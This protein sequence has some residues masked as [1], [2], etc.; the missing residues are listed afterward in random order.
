MNPE[1][2]SQK[3]EVGGCSSDCG[4]APAAD[5]L[6]SDLGP[7][8]SGRTY[9]R[10]LDDLADTPEF[11]EFMHREFPAGASELLDSGDRRNFLKIMG[12]S[13]ALAGMSVGGLGGCRRWPVEHIVPYAARPENRVPGVPVQYATSMEIGGVAHGLLATSFDG[14]PIKIEGNPEHPINRGGT[15]AVTQASILD[16][17]DPDRSMSPVRVVDGER[18]NAT[19][20]EFA[21]WAQQRM[22]QTRARR[23]HGLYVLC[24]ATNSPSV[25]ALKRRLLQEYT[26]L[27]WIEW[28]PVNNDNEHHGSVQAFGSPHRAVHNF[29]R[30]RVIVSLESDFLLTHPAMVKHTRD[31]ATGRRPPTSAQ[32]QEMNRLYVCEAGFSVTGAN[33]DHRLAMRSAEV[34]DVAAQLAAA[35]GVQGAA[36]SELGAR[37]SE[38]VARMAAD[39]QQHRGEGVV[40]AGPTQPPHVH[41]LVHAMNEHLGNAGRTIDYLP[42][43][44]Q[45]AHLDSLRELVADMDGGLIETLFI[46]GGNPAYDAPADFSFAER[47]AALPGRNAAAAH[48][49]LY[50]DETSHL[51]EWHVNRAHYLEA[52][53]DGRA[54]D[55][56]HTLAQPLIEPLFGGR[57]A[58][59]FLAA[60]LGEDATGHQ[61][62]Q[63]TFAALTGEEDVDRRWLRALHDGVVENHTPGAAAVSVRALTPAPA[64]ALQARGEGDIE[65]ILT[66]DPYL[67]D[68]RFANNGWLQELADPM[69]KITWDN[70]LVLNPATAER[71]GVKAGDMVALSV[72][73][74]E[75]TVAV[76]TLPGH[77][78]GSATL[79]LGYGRPFEGRISTGAGFNAYTLRTSAQ[80]HVMPASVRKV[81]GGAG[82]YVLASIQDHFPFDQPVSRR[83]QQDRLPSIFREAT[84]D[85]YERTP[86]F[87]KK[88][89]G[90]HVMHRLSAWSETHPFHSAAGFPGAEYAWAMSIDLSACTGCQA[91]VVACQSENNIP[92]VGKDQINR[93]REMH[94]LR[95]DRYFRGANGAHPDAVGFMP[96]PCMHCEN[97]PCEQVCPV[98]ATVHDTDGLNVMVYNRCIGTRYCSN[99]CPYKVRRFNYFDYYRRKPHRETGMMHVDAEYYQTPQAASHPLRQMQ[100]NPEVTLRSRGVMEKCTFCVQRIVHHRIKA[101]NE[102]RQTAV[103]REGVTR[104]PIP[105]GTFTTACAQACPAQAIVFGDWLD[106]DSRVSKAHAHD[107]SYELLEELNTKPRTRYLGKL[108]NPSTA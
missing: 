32:A 5:H 7:L 27:R 59:E 28:E 88:Q 46:I 48:L 52:W 34:A 25:L 16:L 56:T 91:C 54:W 105:D 30:A 108:R 74:R 94:W 13:M 43:P 11:R 69:T 4:C 82:S 78:E 100:W 18:R 26:A 14:R 55:A 40:I 22:E 79:A 85:E 57:S 24:E 63:S 65:L 20:A 81:R 36:N 103:E 104:I 71:L 95:V 107:R 15:D 39:L 45:T 58:I 49:S 2:R 41:A 37:N 31:F 35:I 3:S 21:E 62:V 23:G 87:V 12:A 38:L 89:P 98:A 60:L 106:P 77:G 75:L 68:G 33:A 6:T 76:M 64:Q 53:G 61:I 97:A 8:T 9:W 86:N 72:G 73:E 44:E 50:D 102:W 96:V 80:M 101:R 10:S 93:N 42:T 83:G 90:L 51:C 17:Y 1:V 99:N 19:W 47:L 92:I 66:P 29:D 84:R 70:A 67:Y